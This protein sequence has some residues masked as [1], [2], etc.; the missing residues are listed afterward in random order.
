MNLKDISAALL[1]I[2]ICVGIG[3][4]LHYAYAE[5]SLYRVVHKL[6][7]AGWKLYLDTTKCGYCVR[8]VKF[9]REYLKELETIHC[10]DIQNKEKC[11]GVKAFPTWEK[12]EVKVP[13]SRFSVS[14]LEK[15]LEH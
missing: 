9:L 11:K 3:L 14:D 8:Q 12:N 4:G 2:M 10:D 5:F 7:D 6:K 15:L 1:L 13:G